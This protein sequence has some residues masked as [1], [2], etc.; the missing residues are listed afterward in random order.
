MKAIIMNAI[1]QQ[2]LKNHADHRNEDDPPEQN[3][4]NQTIQ[5]PTAAGIQR[6]GTTK[7]TNTSAK[8]K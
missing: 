2:T 1:T 7:V 4:T 6:T 5:Q 3:H 8:V